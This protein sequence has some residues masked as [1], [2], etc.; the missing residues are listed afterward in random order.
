MKVEIKLIF[1]I[2]P[3]S[4]MTKNWRKNLDILRT[5]RALKMKQKA[6]FIIFKWLSVVQT[7]NIFLE[8]E[9]PTLTDFINIWKKVRS[10]QASISINSCTK[11]S[12][13]RS[14]SPWVSLNENLVIDKTTLSDLLQ[15]FM[16]SKLLYSLPTQ[17][18]PGPNKIKFPRILRLAILRKCNHFGEWWQEIVCKHFSH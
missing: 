2:K 15:L 1:L 11:L 12:K 18:I 7:K 13:I 16:L 6:F 5:K 10:S 4:Y 3:F 9:S 14:L 8:A 17:C